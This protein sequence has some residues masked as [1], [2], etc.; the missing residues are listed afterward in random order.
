MET[1][2]SILLMVRPNMYMAKLDIKDAYYSIPIEKSCQKMLKF[3]FE[4]AL[5]QFTSLP[6]G[7]TEGPRKFTKILKPPLASLRMEWNILVAAYIDDLITMSMTLESC[8]FNVNKIIDSLVTLGFV[9][10][11]TKSEFLPSQTIE[12]LGFIIN[13]KQIIVSLTKEKKINIMQ[14]CEELL[15]NQ[16]L[17]I[18]RVAKLL[19]KISSSII[20]VIM[21]RLHYRALEKDKIQALRLNKGN[22]EAKMYISKKGRDD[23]TWWKTNIMESFSP[24]LRDNPTIEL[25]ADASSYGWGESLGSISSGGQFKTDEQK[26]HINILELKAVLFGLRALCRNIEGSHILLHID[27]SSA[28]AAINKMGSLTSEDMDNVVHEIWNW[29]ISQKNW[30]TA[31]HIPGVEN[32]IADKESRAQESRTEWMLNRQ[33]FQ[34]VLQKLNFIPD[35]DLF[36]SRLN[37]Q[38]PIF[39]SYRPDP[40]SIAVDAFTLNWENKKFYAFPPF[41]CVAN[42]LQKIWK[43]Q[44]T[45][46][47][48][49]PNWPNQI[50][51]CQYSEM[52]IHEFIL[53]PRSNLLTLPSKGTKHPLNKTLALKAALV[54]GKQSS[55]NIRVRTCKL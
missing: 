34:Q 22:F 41:I 30:V 9:V 45:G 5:Y 28:V 4:G 21:G 31:T 24:I 16:D 7:Y 47:L 52:V 3:T 44:A 10:H 6:N 13:S 43:D 42:V 11:P 25:Y 49:V 15:K 20:A 1:I 27:N 51:Y 32:I 54:S 55:R 18:R 23:I 38:L 33:D 40:E 19:G 26:L 39:V 35:I 12:Y 53:F 17:T 8:I 36:A 46:I 48:I 37:K 29:V 50:W 2:S 14:F